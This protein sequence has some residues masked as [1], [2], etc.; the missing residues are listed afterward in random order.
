MIGLQW[1]DPRLDGDRPL[2][3]PLAGQRDAGRRGWATTGLMVLATLL[4]AVA[5]YSFSLSV[6]ASRADLQRIERRNTALEAQLKALDAEL[7][8][9]ARMPQ[10]QR[11]NDEVLG[12][13]PITAE[14]YLGQPVLL[15]AYA[16]ERPT[17]AIAAPAGPIRA[18]VRI[19]ATGPAAM[20]TATAPAIAP[21]AFTPAQ[22]VYA[23][24]ATA[25]AARPAAAA[26]ARPRRRDLDPALVA[27]I[28]AAARR[29]A[30]HAVGRPADLLTQ[31]SLRDAA[32]GDH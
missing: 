19:E 10:L 3:Q 22:P 30:A 4:M 5:G 29:E 16:V 1:A 12:L 15:A 2:A 21:R 31:V 17:P 28:E 25:P 32:F 11:W 20:L 14:Q 18:A 27:S 13:M 8:V 26:P 23:A 7:R 9:R 6:S 24:A